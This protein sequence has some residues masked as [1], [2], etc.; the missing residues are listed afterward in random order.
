MVEQVYYDGYN[1]K[2]EQ[3]FRETTASFERVIKSLLPFED[4]DEK[5]DFYKLIRSLEVIPIKFESEYLACKERKAHF[6]A[7]RF[8][9]TISFGQGAKLKRSSRL[10]RRSDGYW[11][12]DA[13]YDDNL[14]LMIDEIET[15]V[16][17][18]D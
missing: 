2:E 9:A 7:M 4:S 10:D 3:V 11:V 16:G 12:A 13:R 14:G 8:I 5:D 18:I 17:I 15:D 1:D 6:E